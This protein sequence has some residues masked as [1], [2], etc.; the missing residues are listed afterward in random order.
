MKTELKNTSLEMYTIKLPNFEGPLDLLL[1]FIKRD[2]LDI[3]DIPIARITRE[4]LDFIRLM[5]LFDLELAGEFLVMASS[6]MQ[7][8]VR[9]LLPKEVD[10]SGEE[11]P[12]EDPRAELV[13]QLLQYSQ[14]K[15]VSR[16]FSERE[17]S[18]RYVY[19][20]QVFDAEHQSDGT[21]EYK[22]ATLFDLLAAFKKALERRPPQITLHT[23]TLYPITIEE[24][25]EN[26]LIRIRKE[27]R[28]SFVDL[29]SGQPRLYIVVTFLALLEMSKNQIISIRQN[30]NFD[31]IDIQPFEDIIE[32]KSL[33]EVLHPLNI[34]G[35]GDGDA[36]LPDE[37]QHHAALTAAGESPKHD[38]AEHEHSD[39][40]DITAA[41]HADHVERGAED[42]DSS[43]H[44]DDN[45]DDDSDNE[46]SA[47]DDSENDDTEDDDNDLDESVD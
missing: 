15:E 37:R 30:D 46:D 29:V 34:S 47:D 11:L 18:Q 14:Y 8:K 13:Q 6:L 43:V 44:D 24:Q 4:F 17:E 12:G 36:E 31:D 7:I 40:S 28:L 33:E 21:E 26:I 5:Q 19:Y 16:D 23:V 9:M 38:G 1:F 27:R 32:T 20:R 45:D 25:T 2:E 41:V 22:N 39:E 35:S 42:D 3:Y 10:E